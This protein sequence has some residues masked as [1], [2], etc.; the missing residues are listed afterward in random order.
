MLAGLQT[1]YKPAAAGS[2]YWS[3]QD[4]D[5][6][7]QFAAAEQHLTPTWFVFAPWRVGDWAMGR[8]RGA[9]IARE[10]HNLPWE[11]HEKV[12]L[13]ADCSSAKQA[14]RTG[15]GLTVIGSLGPLQPVVG[16]ARMKREGGL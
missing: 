4:R 10:A 7:L 5:A 16:A 3:S 14:T 11:T 13:W 2:R 8:K 12:A 1:S 6:N 9:L 15:F